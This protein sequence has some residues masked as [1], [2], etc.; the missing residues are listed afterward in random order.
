MILDTG[1]TFGILRGR[2]ATFSLI[3][4]MLNIAIVLLQAA[5]PT[6]FYQLMSRD[7]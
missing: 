7:W 3:I 2:G 4:L 6:I 1:K 5:N